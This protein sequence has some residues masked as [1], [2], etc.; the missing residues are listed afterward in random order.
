MVKTKDQ[1]RLCESF[2]IYGVFFLGGGP[3]ALKYRKYFALKFF[4][5]GKA[6]TASESVG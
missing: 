2:E 1:E 4:V 5:M 3:N 6:I